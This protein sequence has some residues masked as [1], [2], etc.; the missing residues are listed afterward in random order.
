MTWLS[1]V[2]ANGIKTKIKPK[3]N[4]N[5]HSHKKASVMKMEEPAKWTRRKNW[6]GKMWEKLKKFKRAFV[7]YLT[8]PNPTAEKK[9]K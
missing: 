8:N 6:R 1:L 9:T 7:R 4:C 2:S 5:I 3:R